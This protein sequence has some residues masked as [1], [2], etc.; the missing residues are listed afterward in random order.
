MIRTS[1]GEG[2]VQYENGDGNCHGTGKGN[3]SICDE[4][5]GDGDRGGFRGDVRQFN[6]GDGWGDGIGKGNGNGGA[7]NNNGYGFGVKIS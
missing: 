1:F 3:G 7:I 2:I 5:C 6:N 4:G